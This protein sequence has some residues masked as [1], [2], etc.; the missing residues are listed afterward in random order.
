MNMKAVP[1]FSTL[2]R[3]FTNGSCC[4][5]SP[6]PISLT[7]SKGTVLSQHSQSLGLMSCAGMGGR[8]GRRMEGQGRELM[9]RI[10]W[11]L[12]KSKFNFRTS[13]SFQNSGLI[14][15]FHDVCVLR[16]DY[17]TV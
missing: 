13:N 10:C 2:H 16:T 14:L 4:S 7:C 1:G 8:R 5:F 15:D 6:H 12:G 17:V 9:G 11:V 3:S